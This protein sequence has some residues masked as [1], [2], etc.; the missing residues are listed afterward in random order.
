MASQASAEEKIQ[1]MTKNDKISY[2][3]GYK[4]GSNVKQQLNDVDQKILIQGIQDALSGAQPRLTQKEM[5]T[6]EETFQKERA[7]KQQEQN[8]IIAEKNLKEGK[9]FLAENAKK[10]GVTT[11]PSGL[12]YKVITAGKGKRPRTEDEVVVNYRGTLIDGTV[13]DD[14]NN[15]QVHPTIMPM[16]GN[17]EL[18]AGWT[19]ALLL[20]NEG[21]KWRIFIPASLGYGDQRLWSVGPNSVLI[22]DVE[23][24]KIR[25]AE[26]VKGKKNN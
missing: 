9:A 18:I 14:S 4:I 13:F 17:K 19:E 12:Q 7:A 1:I 24:L 2:T 20:M 6:A 5:I 15:H 22:F 23:L 8:R 10:E 25:T 21:A 3:K 16:S 11:L 26:K